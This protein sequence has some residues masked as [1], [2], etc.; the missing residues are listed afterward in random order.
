MSVRVLHVFRTYLPDSKGGTQE[1]I[2]QICRS[3]MPYGIESRVF[4]PSPR[5]VPRVVEI[6]GTE[7]HRVHLNLEIASCG[8]SFTGIPEFR[9]Q[10]SWADV[11]HYHYPWPFADMLHYLGRVT[12]P[13]ILTYHSDIVRQKN[14]MRLYT[15][16]MERFL[17]DV[18]QIVCTSENYRDSSPNLQHRANEVAVIPIGLDPASYPAP[19]AAQINPVREEFGEGFF[20][21]VGMLRYYK[22]LHVL[23]DACQGQDFPVVIAGKGP[24]EAELK[25][26]AARL[27][28]TNVK[29]AGE[30]P[31][32]TKMALLTLCRAV[33]FPSYERSE[34]FGVTLL[35]GQLYGRPAIT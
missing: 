13:T 18:D 28:L 1:V 24:M 7:V 3:T 31:D 14:L 21:F 33:V 5:P 26:Q 30:V 16:L 8:F 2:R 12:K 35:E 20:L 32:E 6:E 27:G 11:V 34:A 29:F 9:R 10:V 23:L 19:C 25:Q 22:G 17:D 15:P 4:A